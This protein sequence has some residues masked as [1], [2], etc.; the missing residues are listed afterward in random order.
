MGLLRFPD[1]LTRLHALS[2]ADN[3]GLGLIVLGLLPRVD[4]TLVARE[5]R[6][7]V[8]AR[9]AVGCDR[10]AA[11]RARRAQPGSPR[12]SWSFAVDIAMVVLLLAIAVFT[13]AVRNTFAAIIAFAAYG[14]LVAVV[15]VRLQAVDVALTEAAIGSGL[16]GVLMLGAAARLRRTERAARP[17]GPR[18][19]CASSR[20]CSPRRS[21]QRSAPR[22]RPSPDPAPTLAPA[23]IAEIDATGLGNPVTAVLMAYRATDTLLEK[24][25]L[26]LAVVGVWSLAPD[27]AWG[28]RPGTLYRPDADG[29]L[30][31]FARVLPPFGVVIGIYLMWTAADRSRRRLRRRHRA[32][33]DVG[34]RDDGG[35]RRRAALSQRGAAPAGARRTGGVRRGRVRRHGDRG[36]VPCLPGRLTRNR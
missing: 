9:A 26:V 22:C 34:A 24:V 10:R 21:R 8:A 3:L 29:V 31:F 2:K 30:T 25:V 28:G 27:R 5:A 6:V 32:R 4:G 35:A 20:P 7:R 1:T 23:A 14:L 33:G 16:T 17:S 18:P 15:W 36:R 13:I 12:V 19:G 11:H